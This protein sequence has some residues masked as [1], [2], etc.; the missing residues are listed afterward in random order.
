M[1]NGNIERVF[2]NILTV[3][4]EAVL[5]FYTTKE[6]YKNFNKALRGEI[7]I[8][9]FFK[10]QKKLMNSALD[11]L[12]NYKSKGVLYRIE[13][14][15]E[16]QINNIY[17]KGEV[18]KNKHFTSSTYD[19]D[20]IAEAMRNRPYTVMILIK[21]SKS[22][23]LIENLSTLKIEKEVLFRSDIEFIVEK[24]SIGTNPE[25]LGAIKTIILKQN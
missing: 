17:K 18:I 5:K 12:P 20:S 1:K 6:G 25:T 13:N 11:K 2:K 10:A 21:D 3:E 4:E 8:T 7:N 22:G 9:D 14:L 15:T 24:I 16:D 23:K 19:I